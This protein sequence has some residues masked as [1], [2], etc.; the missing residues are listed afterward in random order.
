MAK[1]R[2]LD[3]LRGNSNYGKKRKE[4]KR[5]VRMIIYLRFY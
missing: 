3:E 4:K 5:C 2:K 1:I